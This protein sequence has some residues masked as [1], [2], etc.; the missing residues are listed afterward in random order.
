[1]RWMSL[2][3]GYRLMRGH[4]PTSDLRTEFQKDFDRIVFS[5][6]F[7]RLQDKTQIFPLSTND[8]VHTRLTHSI[9]VAC[10]ARSLGTLVGD[11]VG[12]RGE[13]RGVSPHEFGAV[14]SAAALAHDIGNPPFGHEGEAAVRGWFATEGGALLERLNEDQRR[15]LLGFDGNAQGFRILA[16]LQNARDRGGMQ[17]TCAVLGAFTKYPHLPR[18]GSLKCGF[19]GVDRPLFEQV[20][21]QL[22]LQ[23]SS[24]G[25]WCRHPL[26]YVVEAADDICYSVVDVED[27]YRLG[28]ISYDDIHVLL[29]AIASEGGRIESTGSYGLLDE[30]D[31][32]VGYLR[33]RSIDALVTESFRVFCKYYD[34]I[35]SGGP[36]PALVTAGVF[37]E[38]LAQIVAL[39]RDRLYPPPELG[40]DDSLARRAIAAILRA[41]LL[42]DPGVDWHGVTRVL[43]RLAGMTDSFAARVAGV[44]A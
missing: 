6:A 19:Y 28:L 35:M 29:G 17:L 36:A 10:V 5:S 11:Y 4:S 18:A 24:S 26:A 30:N 27:G 40:G 43:D 25:G 33:A 7:R 44:M 20:A 3:S 1:M 31:A 42:S 13:V 9:E 23:P 12:S 22:G 37:A 14:A 2:L 8:Y 41:Q 15:H 39:S 38:R 34:T 16:R 21:E 32:R